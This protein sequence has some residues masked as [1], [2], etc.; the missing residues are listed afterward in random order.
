MGIIL[1]E[2]KRRFKGELLLLGVPLAEGFRDYLKVAAA[3]ISRK[4]TQYQALINK[5][6]YIGRRRL[7]KM[8]ALVLLMLKVSGRDVL[9][10]IASEIGL[11]DREDEDRALMAYIQAHLHKGVM[12]NV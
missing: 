10:E 6:D 8:N 9:G 12:E 7:V 11:R 5:Y 4:E 3:A 2:C 1:E